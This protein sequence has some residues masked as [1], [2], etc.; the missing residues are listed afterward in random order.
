MFGW[1]MRLFERSPRPQVLEDAA[2]YRRVLDKADAAVPDDPRMKR[3]LREFAI[4]E[5]R[6]RRD[7]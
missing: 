7:G 4:A 3:V 2:H 6:L 1:L 5:E